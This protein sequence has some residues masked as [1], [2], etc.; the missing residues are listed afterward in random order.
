M[1]RILAK[2]KGM[3]RN[4]WLELRKSGIGG[5]DAGAI[6]GVNPYANALSV[7][8]DK[9]EK[10]IEDSDNE[11]MRQGRDFEDYVARRFMEETGLKVR[12]SNVMYQNEKHPFMI[13]DIDRLVVG[14][15]AGLECKTV[16]PYNADKWKDGQAPLHYV[17][18]CLHYME[19]TGKKSWYIAGLIFGSEF[20]FRKIHYDPVLAEQ[21]IH[22][23]SDFWW[24]NVQKRRMPAPDGTRIYDDILQKY[25]HSSGK[26]SY[27]ELIGFD[28]KLIQREKITARIKELTSEQR[29]IEQ[30][31]KLYMQNNEKAASE[32]FKVSWHNVRSMR[33][34]TKKLKEEKPEIYAM[35]TKESSTRRFE[36][37]VTSS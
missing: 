24:N 32:K 7:Y 25:F 34:D 29:R 9:T 15:D 3:P 6:C 17:L 12:R 11:A 26:E 23:E 2:T 36:V 8:R 18:Q 22:I 35:Y 28:E 31:I 20:V 19:V 21:L 4:M 1:C 16:S 13:G 14:E 5:S 30:E 27:I 10:D 37:R 33:L